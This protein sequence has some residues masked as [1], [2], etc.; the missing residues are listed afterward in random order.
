[1]CQPRGQPHP[2]TL[3]LYALGIS[4]VASDN[5]GLLKQVFELKIKTNQYRPEELLT[6]PL[7]PLRVFD[8]DLSKRLLPG[9]E[10]EF[11]PFK[12]Y[13]FEVLRDIV[14]DVVPDD[15]S[16]D[17]AFDWFEYLLGLV[18]CDQTATPEELE[19][20]KS[21]A[22]Q[23]HIWG[24]IGRFLWNHR[25]SDDAVQRR[26]QFEPTGPYPECVTAIL[27]VGFF[28]SHFTGLNYERFALI[29]RGFDSR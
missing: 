29:K 12:N 10:N 15:R 11:T 1:L 9:R 2:A 6:E 24:P 8:R 16:Y 3:A 23:S 26:T 27:Q 14:R 18:H 17:E 20:V 21:R 28:G 25:N 5:Y 4:A 7:S 19:G 13:L 22:D